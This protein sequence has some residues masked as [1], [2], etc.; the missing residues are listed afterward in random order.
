MPDN[1][2]LVF[3]PP[4]SPELNPAEN[5]WQYLRQT[6]LGNRVFQDYEDIVNRVCQAWRALLDEP[7]RIASITH[8]DWAC[9]G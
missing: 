4:V 6:Y 7:G 5:V 8:R 2:S 1:L 9:V 3:L